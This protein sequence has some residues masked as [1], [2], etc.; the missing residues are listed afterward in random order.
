LSSPALLGRYHR[1]LEHPVAG[2]VVDVAPGG[3]PDPA[4]LGRQGVR[5]VVAVQVG[6]GD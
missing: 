1:W 4:D 5:Q 3:D 6:G 2:D